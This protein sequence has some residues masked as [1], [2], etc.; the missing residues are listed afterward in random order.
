M[1][2]EA[3]TKGPSFLRKVDVRDLEKGGLDST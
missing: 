1:L 2:A 3:A